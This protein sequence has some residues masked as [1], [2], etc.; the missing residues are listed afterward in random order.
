[1]SRR[2]YVCLHRCRMTIAGKS[3]FHVCHRLPSCRQYRHC[4]SHGA[5]IGLAT[6]FMAHSYD[7]VQRLRSRRFRPCPSLCYIHALSALVAAAA[8]A[9]AF[10][11]KTLRQTT[12]RKKRESCVCLALFGAKRRVVLWALSDG[13]Q[14]C[15]RLTLATWRWRRSCCWGNQASPSC[16][17]RSVSYT[18]L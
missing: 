7:R 3:R 9:A 12:Q 10:R 11:G 18:H 1:M 5:S 17:I 8:A 14:R 15:R 6:H 13:K 16:T 2:P 4:Q